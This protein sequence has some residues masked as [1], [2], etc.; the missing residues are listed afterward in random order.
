ML[1]KKF[2]CLVNV[3]VLLRREGEIIDRREVHNVATTAGKQHIADQLASTHDEAEM[4]H[5]AIGTGSDAGAD[6][7][8]LTNELSRKA[9]DSR[10]QLSGNDANKVEYKATW[11][12]GEGT[13]A[14]TEA[15]IFNAASGGTL[16]CYA[17]FSAINKGENDELVITWTVS[18]T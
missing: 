5:M 4:S 14:I 10:N 1:G 12:A 6:P 18:I 3:K 13:G 7:T 8:A 15:G 9:L 17:H 2:H 16:L 11:A